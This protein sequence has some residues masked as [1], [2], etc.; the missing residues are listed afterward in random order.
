MSGNFKICSLVID[1]TT[2]T[3]YKLW[4]LTLKLFGQLDKNDN[5]LV[6]DN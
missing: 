5:I 6:Y 2:I 4:F 3:A 1:L